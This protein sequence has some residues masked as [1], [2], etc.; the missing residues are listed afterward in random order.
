MFEQLIPNP[1]ITLVTKLL[2]YKTTD[3][4]GNQLLEIKKTRNNMFRVFYVVAIE[5]FK[6]YPPF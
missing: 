6:I 1:T 4:V 2:K 5:N 3:R